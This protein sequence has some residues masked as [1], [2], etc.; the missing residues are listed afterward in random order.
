[1]EDQAPVTFDPKPFQIPAPAAS[2]SAPSMSP[3][4]CTNQPN[5]GPYV[6]GDPS[7]EAQRTKA[8]ADKS[9]QW[10]NGKTL[11]VVFLNGSDDAWGQTLQQAVKDIAPIWSDYANIKFDFVP[12][13][14]AHITVNFFPMAGVA[15]AGTYNSYIGTDSLPN[16]GPRPTMNLV[17]DQGSL[18][19]NQAFMQQEFHRVIIHEFG[20]ALGFIHEHMRPDRPIIWN[21]SALNRTFGV[22]P[23]SWCPDM[24]RAQIIDFYQPT[25]GAA[26][27]MGGAFDLTSIMMYQFGPGLATYND[28]SPFQSPNNVA[29]S[30][31][32][33]VVASMLYPATGVTDPNEVPIVPGDPPVTGSIQQAGQVVRFSFRPASG[34][35]HFIET[36]G[37]T[38]LLVSLLSIRDD[39]AGRMLAVEGSTTSLGFVPTNPG[40]SYFIQVR[41]AKPMSGTGDF[42]ISVHAQS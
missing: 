8:M 20:H 34:A 23:N 6:P 7:T 14:Q 10:A 32:D 18:S 38:P 36:Q 26:S 37:T 21:E 31:L 29:L 42:S 27:L 5:G 41:H 30:P 4:L 33:K 19:S 24:I 35:A 25:G 13:P 40:N 11:K 22:P 1:M 3:V 28:G 39:P 12:P 17:F 15:G 2:T 9:K 16:I